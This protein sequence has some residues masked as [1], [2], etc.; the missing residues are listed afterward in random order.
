MTARPPTVPVPR[1]GPRGQGRRATL[2]GMT[3]VAVAAPTGRTRGARCP[4]ALRPARRAHGG[5]VAGA[6][7]PRLG[8][9][10]RAARLALRRRAEPRRCAAGRTALAGVW[11]GW[12]ARCCCSPASS[13]SPRSSPLAGASTSSPAG[14]RSPR[15]P[16][17]PPSTSLLASPFGR[18]DVPAVRGLRDEPDPRAP[19]DDDPPAAAV[20]RPGRR[21]RRGRSSPSV[22]PAPW[23]SAR[24]W[25]LA[26]I[27]ALTAA[28]TLGAAWSYLEQGWGGYW[29]WD[30][31]ENTSL[32]VWLAALAALHGGPLA[33]PGVGRGA[34]RRAVGAGDDR[35][36]A[37][38]LRRHAVDPRLRRAARRRL[39]ARRPRRGDHRRPSRRGRRAAARGPPAPVARTRERRDPRAADGRAASAAA[40][41]VVLAGT[42][43]PLRRPISPATARRAVRGE[44][45]SRTVGPLALVAIP[46]LARP[47][48]PLGRAGARSPTPVRSCCSSASPRRRSTAWPPCRSPPA[49]PCG[50]PAATS[51]TTACA[52]TAGPRDGTDAVVADLASTAARCAR[53]SSSTR[54]G[55]AGS[56]RWRRRPGS[57]TDVQVVLD[58][59]AD[60]G[61]GRRHRAR[62]PADVAGL[63][64]RGGRGGRHARR[65]PLT[66]T[67]AARRFPRQQLVDVEP[68]GAGSSAGSL[69]ASGVGGGGGRRRGGGW[70]WR[71]RRRGV[72]RRRVEAADAR[73]GV[74]DAAAEPCRRPCAT[75]RRRRRRVAPRTEMRLSSTA[76]GHS[77]A[78]SQQ[79]RPEQ[80]RR[81]RRAARQT[82]GVPHVAGGDLGATAGRRGDAGRGTRRRRCPARTRPGSCCWRASSCSARPPPSSPAH[83]RPDGVGA[84]ARRVGRALEALGR[85]A[86]ERGPRSTGRR[87]R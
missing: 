45:Y 62:A 24:P 79:Q 9:R 37:R 33:R 29:A 49:P 5:D 65:W 61:D 7:P 15:S 42:V 56:P 36:R 80:A 75:R 54:T 21:V 4:R 2:I 14:Q 57:L 31:V 69:G 1:P 35:R 46:F 63:A 50:P 25:L 47:A 55:A 84:R 74:A 20:R 17:S 13:A 60:D 41:V 26:T 22:P 72:G 48:A 44:F 8:V 53:R 43:L 66:V 81:S 71:W 23:P 16:P 52:S 58:D 83:R 28:M 10:H 76:T 12:R 6:R 87:V 77:R 64:R 27:G 40:A 70:R 73:D 51:S 19:G 34:R 68:V 86:L 30:P 67:T 59:A 32:L 78:A 85:R 38:A 3:D 18:L 39:G 11:A 82:L